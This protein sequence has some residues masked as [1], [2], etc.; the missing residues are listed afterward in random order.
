LLL[1]IEHS[2][3]NTKSEKKTFTYRL[4]GL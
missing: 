4:F 3:S 1:Q 2:E